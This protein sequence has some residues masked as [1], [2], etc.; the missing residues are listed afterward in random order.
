MYGAAGKL[1]R[2][3][4]GAGRRNIHA[5]PINRP[6]SM[7]RPSRGGAGGRGR[8]G[9]SSAATSNRS[10]P[11]ELQVEESFALVREN[12]LNFGMAI[13]LA[14]NLVEEIKR[15]EAE[16]GTAR[17]K[18]DVGAKNPNGNVI[19]VGDK[20]FRFTWS[21]EPGDFCDIYEERERG[22]DGNG[23]L[24]ESGATWRKLNVER[25]LDESTKN[26]LKMRSEEAERKSKSR[27]AIVLDHQTPAVKNQLQDFAAAESNPW[28]NFKNR[29]ENPLK[30]PKSQISSGGPSRPVCK[31]GLPPSG[32]SKVKLSSGSPSSSQLEQHSDSVPPR[33]SGNSVKGQA[34]L[35]EAALQ[36]KIKIASSDK[37]LGA[38]LS[39]SSTFSETVKHGQNTEAKTTDLR[40]LIITLL[41]KHQHKGLSLKALEKAIG[42]ST[43]NSAR[44]IEPILKQIAVFR[45]PEKYFLKPGVEMESFKRL[46][47][48]I[49]SS[50]EIRLESPALQKSDQL[51]AQTPSFSMRTAATDEEPADLNSTP[52]HTVASEENIDILS[53]SPEPFSDQKVSNNIEGLVGSS[54]DSGS[55]SDTDSDSSSD[56]GSRRSR[57]QSPVGSRSGSSSDSDSDSG[58]DSTSSSKQAS[59]DDVD[60][61]MSDDDKESERKLQ[62]FDPVSSKSPLIWNYLDN[63]YPDVG[64]SERHD[65]HVSGEVDIENESPHDFIDAERLRGA[66]HSVSNEERDHVRKADNGLGCVAEDGFKPDQSGNVER[67]SKSGKSKR[68]TDSN[69]FNGR[70]PN[71]KKLK[72]QDLSQPVSGTVSLLFGESPGNASPDRPLDVPDIENT[73]APSTERK[74]DKPESLEHGVRH[75]ERSLQSHEGLWTQKGETQSKDDA[76]ESNYRKSEMPGMVKKGTSHSI[77]HTGYSPNRMSNTSGALQRGQSD[78]ELGELKESFNGENKRD[79]EIW[80]SNSARG[81]TSNSI[82]KDSLSPADPEVAAYIPNGAS[83]RKATEHNADD[84]TRPC[85]K[86]P[87][88][89]HRQNQ[90]P[91]NHVEVGS[92]LNKGPKISNKTRF[93]EAGRAPGQNSDSCRDTSKTVPMTQQ[94]PVSIQGVGLHTTKENTTNMAQDSNDRQKYASLTGHNGAIGEN[95]KSSLDA[96]SSPYT[97]YEK[98]EPELRG[99]IKDVSQ[100]REY[101]KEY[102]V[103]YETYRSLNKILES[104]REDFSKLGKDL[105]ACKGTDM[106][107]YSDILEQIKSSFLECGERHKRLKK[108]FVVLYEELKHLKEMIKDYASAY[109]KG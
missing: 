29:K 44:Q 51:P 35:P 66:I 14:P 63:E 96:G 65:D 101:V 17:I 83:K 80:N 89:L 82:T 37:D 21:R 49:G 90:P 106:K 31:S 79:S 40:S 107:R 23:L 81:K 8:G 22:K 38:S 59:E 39:N 18:F 91:G 64:N 36:N 2:G 12:P 76:K 102:Q 50:P 30:K 69:D 109:Q 77:S 58:S 92:Q 26:H 48:Q 25:E 68:P 98:E 20:T 9:L 99:P 33:V 61:M 108:I 42:D 19:Q 47:P 105:K 13:K 93:A 71:R 100:Y 85:L 56:T 95:M 24:V 67:S 4:G 43:P 70:V 55:V 74:P 46:P 72:S 103:K 41:L 57:S 87:R 3:G 5:P 62:E 104:Y 52:V 75:S 27:R 15:V 73:E 54:S 16:G 28:K 1:G 97:K 34:S 60:I 88:P 32:L 78:L 10:A 6:A 45:S 94:E 84:L 53:N 11:S 86:R 7:V